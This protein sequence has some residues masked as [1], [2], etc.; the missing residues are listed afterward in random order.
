M[1]TREQMTRADRRAR[2]AATRFE[3][4]V[5]ALQALSEHDGERARWLAGYCA[6]ELLTKT[7]FVADTLVGLIPDD[8]DI[9]DARRYADALRQAMRSRELAAKLANVN[10]R[11]PAEAEAFLAKAEALR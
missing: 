1:T 9:S 10:G 8:L 3:R 11:T 7:L 2:D 5:N 4:A 6:R